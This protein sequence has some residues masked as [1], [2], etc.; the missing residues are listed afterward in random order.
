MGGLVQEKTEERGAI[1]GGELRASSRDAHAG[2]LAP[3]RH[4]CLR[5]LS[6]RGRYDFH[7]NSHRLSWVVSP[8]PSPLPPLPPPPAEERSKPLSATHAITGARISPSGAGDQ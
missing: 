1:S 3:L 8:S 4:L 7:R 6:A 5:R 2:F